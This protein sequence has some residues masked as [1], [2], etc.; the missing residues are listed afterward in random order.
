MRILIVA[1]SPGRLGNLLHV[2]FYLAAWS[3]LTGHLVYNPSFRLVA[4]DLF[5]RKSR[6]ALFFRPKYY[7]KGHFFTTLDLV[8]PLF[9]SL[10][11][12][13]FNYLSRFARRFP[14]FTADLPAFFYFQ[15]DDVNVSDLFDHPLCTSRQPVIIF[16]GW[17]FKSDYLYRQY[18]DTLFP[19]FLPSSSVRRAAIE[20]FQTAIAKYSS[21][22]VVGVHIRR[23]DYK[24]FND[25]RYFFPTCVFRNSMV[26]I[27][28]HLLGD[29]TFL[30]FSDERILQSDFN[31]LQVHTSTN[32]PIV[33]MY[34]MS[35][36]AG[37]VGP[38][39]TFSSFA[40]KMWGN[41]NI[42][43]ILTSTTKVSPEFLSRLRP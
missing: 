38:P 11:Y 14:A 22:T 20:T 30:L 5:G 8:P 23:G 24:T 36:C 21:S 18:R 34:T 12:F 28:D 16:A 6:T 39:S 41:S 31:D 29:V 19:F 37:L 9:H 32:S 35:L 7:L 4:P 27:R 10:A 25:G 17:L 42:H 43:S 26:A 33:D 3:L 1:D 2:Y 40:M 13:V 15:Q